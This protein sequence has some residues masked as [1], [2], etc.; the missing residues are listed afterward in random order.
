MKT[1]P[2]CKSGLDRRLPSGYGKR[3]SDIRL[4]SSDKLSSQEGN[5]E[6]GNSAGKVSTLDLGLNARAGLEIGSILLTGFY[7]KWTAMI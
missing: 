6:V 4:M 7:S 1:I 5:L 2:R 3:S